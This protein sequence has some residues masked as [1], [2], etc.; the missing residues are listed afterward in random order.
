MMPTTIDAWYSALIVPS[1]IARLRPL[2]LGMLVLLC[3][4]LTPTA[5]GTPSA[6]AA[7]ACAIPHQGEHLGPTY[8]TALKVGGTSCNTGLAVVR[9][10][11]ACQLKHGGAKGTCTSTVDGFRCSEKRG[12]SIPTEFFSSVSCQDHSKRVIYK[13]MQFT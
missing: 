11:H 9:G 6:E 7:R 8:L 4:V 1:L 10:Y 2:L 12:S 3:F 5:G 13:Y